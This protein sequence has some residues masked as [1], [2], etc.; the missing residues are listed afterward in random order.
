M[1]RIGFWQQLL[2]QNC[3]RQ[4]AEAIN[5]AYDSAE[6]AEQGVE[7]LTGKVGVLTKRVVALSREVALLRVAFTVLARTL[8]DTN[9]VD[10]ELLDV[11]LEA[12]LDEAL[13]P[14]GAATPMTV[15]CVRCRRD[16]PASSTTMTEDGPMCDRC[17]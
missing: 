12:A 15:V 10:G 13:P 8:K 14:P 7:D 6:R 1:A 17:P 9:V 3:S 2:D 16:V 4:E 11:R 5:S